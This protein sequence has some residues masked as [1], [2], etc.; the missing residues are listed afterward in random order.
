MV[1]LNGK[2]LKCNCEIQIP[3]TEIQRY[4]FPSRLILK[5]LLSIITQKGVNDYVK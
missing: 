5:P 4:F 3:P 2:F 1:I